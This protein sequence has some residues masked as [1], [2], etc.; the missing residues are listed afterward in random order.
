MLNEHDKLNSIELDRP[1]G[2]IIV[3]G[4]VKEIR[5]IMEAG[6]M[7]QIP[8]AAVLWEDGSKTHYNLSKLVSFSPVHYT[9][10]L[11]D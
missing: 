1:N 10:T 2:T 11:E 3:G 9:G 5:V 7:A 6:H 8:W 4:N